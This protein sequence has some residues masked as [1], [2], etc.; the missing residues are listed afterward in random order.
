MIR[1]ACSNIDKELAISLWKNCFNDSEKYIN[2]F[3]SN[4]YKYNNFLLYENLGGLH[5]TPYN[6]CFFYSCE[7]SWY[8]QG[9]AVFEKYRRKG[10]LKN[11]MLKTI[12]DANKKGLRE[13]FLIPANP[14][15]YTPYDFEFSHMLEKYYTTKNELC[16][17]LK[18]D[19]YSIIEI[20]SDNLELNY[21]NILDFYH[22]NMKKFNSFIKKDLTNLKLFLAELHLE[23]SSFFYV[24]KNSIFVGLFSLVPHEDNL[25]LR[26]LFFDNKDILSNI[27]N[28]IYNSAYN[29]K[30]IVITAPQGSEI[31]TYFF[32]RLNIKKDIYP[33]IMT[34]IIDIK[35]TLLEYLSQNSYSEIFS[36]IIFIE[37]KLIPS[38][39]GIYTLYFS[40]KTIEFS[41]ESL[42]YDF[43]IDVKTLVEIIYGTTSI[44]TL[45]KQNKIKIKNLEIIETI[46]V[47][48]TL[49]NNY[50]LEY[51]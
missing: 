19:E 1:Y 37:D 2:F 13:I 44:S 8:I 29:F 41:Q 36:L 4:H 9:V 7:L 23:K 30:N 46:K 28:F 12:E 38:N 49:K 50:I 42:N 22:K 33:F 26:D 3:F 24:K 16:D 15:I 39:Q 10:I 21:Q 35:R 40:D 47:I 25:E 32:N 18:N 48:F 51:I 17:F 11:L 14:K 34:R 27:F 5:L 6:H 20:F 45:V 31:E 43:K